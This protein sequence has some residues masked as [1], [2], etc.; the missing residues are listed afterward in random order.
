M[1]GLITLDEDIA[2]NGGVQMA[3]YAYRNWVER[4]GAEGI[5]PG[6]NYNQQQLFWIATAQKMCI[7]SNHNE[8]EIQTDVHSPNEFRV[9]GAFSNMPEFAIDFNC[10]V[11]SHM[12]PVKKCSV[13]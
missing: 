1:N 4:N 10:P 6:M 8:E 7:T 13:W 12:N 11:G 3:Y 5:L 2:D 9:E